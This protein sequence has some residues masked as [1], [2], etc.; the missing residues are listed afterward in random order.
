MPAFVTTPA[1]AR[2]GS[3]RVVYART[4]VRQ[5][6][7]LTGLDRR[8]PPVRTRDGALEALAAGRTTETGS[9]Q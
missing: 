6:F 5:L 1:T 8:V 7:R 4:R 3:L 9:R 2:G